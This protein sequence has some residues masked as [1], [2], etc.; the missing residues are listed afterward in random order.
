MDSVFWN[1]TLRL[2]HRDNCEDI[3]SAIMA[4]GM[5]VLSLEGNAL[6]GEHM[7]NVARAL[8]ANQWLVGLNFAHNS[9]LGSEVRDLV[10]QV[11]TSTLLIAMRIEGNPGCS[12]KIASMLEGA[13]A[14]S[15]VNLG[16]LSKA[17]Q[18]VLSVWLSRSDADAL[19]KG[20]G[21]VKAD[22]DL[23]EIEA[24]ALTSPTFVETF[25]SERFLSSE[26]GSIDRSA[27]PG[28]DGRPPSRRSVRPRGT[29]DAPPPR[30]VDRQSRGV[31]R[32]V[33]SYV[34]VEARSKSAPSARL[35]SRSS[36]ET[37]RVRPPSS[38]SGLPRKTKSTRALPA[39]ESPARER[40]AG[41]KKK[42]AVVRDLTKAV[43]SI[44]ENLQT[45]SDQLRQVSES[46]MQSAELQRSISLNTSH[47]RQHLQH[48]S[49]LHSGGINTY[50]S[51]GNVF[52][53]ATGVDRS[54]DEEEDMLLTD[55][56]QLSLRGKLE[57]FASNDSISR[58]DG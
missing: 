43:F 1:E 4:R 54:L 29:L 2:I 57:Q 42:T 41:K 31:D 40:G 37:H 50:A 27:L 22:E 7:H 35:V 14:H 48:S 15:Q 46:L 53:D 30:Q 38:A 36:V 34:I 28:T 13:L 25:A 45:V 12:E 56:I 11:L 32:P 44:T 52:D 9:L 23:S 58:D 24:R 8:G 33:S 17:A 26:W 6:T 16:T 19:A 21:W 5:V 51:G 49:L 55:L 20:Q 18:D 39:S 10:T 3:K 47:Q